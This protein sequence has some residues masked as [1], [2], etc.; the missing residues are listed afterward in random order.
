MRGEIT[1][2]DDLLLFGSR[3]VV[4]KSLQAETLQ[5]IHHGHQ[6]IQRCRQRMSTAVWWPGVSREIETFVKS[7]PSC[8]KTTTPPREPLLQSTLPDHPWERIASDLFQLNGANYLLVVD[9]YSRYVE[10][11][12]LHSTS[13]ASVITALKAL[14]SCHGIPSTLVSDNGP[15]YDSHEMKQFAESYGFCHLTS[16]PHYPQANGQAERA[17]RT[18]K[19]LLEHSP[20][21]Y[22]ALLSYRATPMPWCG[23]SPSELLMGRRIRTDV[24]QLKKLLVPNWPHVKDFRSLDE[25]F[26]AEQKHNYD[27][28]HRVRPLPTL[29]DNLPVWVDNQGTQVPGEIV[30]QASSLRSYLVETPT[31]QVRRNCSHIRVRSENTSDDS[32]GPNGTPDQPEPPRVIATRSRTGTAIR[33]PDRLSPS[34]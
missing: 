34:T 16:S 8:Q 26:K 23:L 32:N 1:F 33:P 22:M 25:K 2:C 15:Q 10:V 28:R 18:V 19:G 7:C 20:D 5:K 6:G 21:P 30:Q 27:V 31:G 24:P 3:I 9:Y 29:P 12:K 17:V 14:F 4:P 11:Q 13:S